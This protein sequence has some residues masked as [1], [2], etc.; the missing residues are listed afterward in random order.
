MAETM[1]FQSKEF[2]RKLLNRADSFPSGNTAST[3]SALDY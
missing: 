2:F 3:V 1:P